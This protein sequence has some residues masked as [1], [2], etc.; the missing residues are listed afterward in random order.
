M[1]FKLSKSEGFTLIELIISIGIMS[2][3]VLVI[4]IFSFDV[5]DFGIFLGENITAQQETQLTLRVMVS[6]MR[7]MAQAVNG[8]YLIES[9]SQNSV[10]FYSD[11][12]GD[13]F[14][15]RIRYFLDGN[16]LKKG[17]IKPSG[18]PL[19]YSGTETIDEVVHNIY[20]A[21]G[22]I[23]SYYDSNYSGTQTE[24]GFPMNIP[25]V[26]LIKINLTV[27]PNPADT[28][29]RINFSTSVNIRNL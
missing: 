29:S 16:I 24:L 3:I 5:F 9:A 14:A 6:E 27:D 15:E 1:N 11:R 26:R 18:N 23:F 4:S 13:G 10:V 2:G 25:L 19:A 22:N 20:S 17:V 8:A 7:A 12:D 21:A 28:S